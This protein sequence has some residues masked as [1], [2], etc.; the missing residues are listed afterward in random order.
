MCL[1]QATTN[2]SSTGQTKDIRKKALNFRP[3]MWFN[4]AGECGARPPVVNHFLFFYQ[5]FFCCCPLSCNYL[6][7]A[8][9]RWS[10]LTM[11]PVQSW[12]SNHWG[13]RE[14][15]LYTNATHP[16]LRARSRL[17]PD[18]V[19]S[20]VSEKKN[21]VI[22]I[23]L[24]RICQ[25]ILSVIQTLQW[26]YVSQSTDCRNRAKNR[27]NHIQHKYLQPSFWLDKMNPLLASARLHWGLCWR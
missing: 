7:C 27:Q 15:K 10:S 26:N 24:Q 11:G 22:K 18:S 17:L 5:H 8:F 23:I 13:P 6:P 3:E 2:Q 19:C 16:T 9:T 21:L 1:N 14:M 4:F 20:E 25:G 12:G